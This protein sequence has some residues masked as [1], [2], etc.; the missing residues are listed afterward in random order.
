M[1]HLSGCSIHARVVWTHHSLTRCNAWVEVL[2]LTSGIF[3]NL[4][5]HF[6]FAYSAFQFSLLLFQLCRSL[7]GPTHTQLNHFNFSSQVHAGNSGLTTAPQQV[8]RWRIGWRGGHSSH[9]C[10]VCVFG[11]AAV[12]EVKPAAL[13]APAWILMDA[14]IIAHTITDVDAIRAPTCH[15]LSV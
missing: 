7:P 4:Q 11:G 3:W 1:F 14:H 2:C 5:A 15:Y 12:M 9:A 13:T 10:V 6:S 8:F